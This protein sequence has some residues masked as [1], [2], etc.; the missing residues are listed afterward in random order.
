MTLRFTGAAGGVVHVDADALEQI[1][2]NLLGNVEKYAAD[3]GRVE[4]SSRQDGDFCV[5]RV[6]DYGPGV[7]KSERQ[8]VFEPFYRGDRRLEQGAG[9]SG[10]GLSISRELARLHGGDVEL[11]DCAPGTLVEVRLRTAEDQP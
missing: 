4:I 11:V 8:R 5:I 10:I 1:I 7:A 9:G 3:G 6:R 2:N